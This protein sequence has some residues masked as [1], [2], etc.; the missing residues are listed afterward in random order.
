MAD[1]GEEDE[2]EKLI[3]EISEETL[4]ETIGITQSKVSYFMNRFR[5]LGLIDY[6]GR[7]RVRKALLNVILHDQFLDDNA[8]KP[9]II[10]MPQSQ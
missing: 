3:A 10:D 2:S 7:I 5:E 4:A 6:D 8:V 9:A 1:F